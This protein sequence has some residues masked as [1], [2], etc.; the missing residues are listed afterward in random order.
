MILSPTAG[1]VFFKPV[2]TAGSSIEFALAQSCGPNDLLVGGM[3]GEE[4][5]SGFKPQNNV[6][7]EDGKIYRKFHTHTFPTFLE[8]RM[9]SEQFSE[10]E[11]LKWITMV[12]NPWAAVVSYYW[13]NMRRDDNEK[14]T[15]N[16]NTAQKQTSDLFH[17]VM[18]S[19]PVDLESTDN[20]NEKDFCT[21]HDF[22]AKHNIQMA[23]DHRIDHIIRFE[24]LQE[25]FD[26][27]TSELYLHNVPIP[28]FKTTQ[29]KVK[30]HY[31]FYYNDVTK[32]IVGDAFK[33]YI[34][35]FDYKFE[36]KGRKLSR[37]DRA[38]R[39]KDKKG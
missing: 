17:Q 15:I 4:S 35:K 37:R 3:E 9:T 18:F 20:P 38:K 39:R 2:K 25:D 16:E 19:M 10:I 29:Q 5:G 12:R 30:R 27:V 28:R 6:Y 26:K 31:S 14:W 1:F 33:D 13:W 8:N 22:V 36:Y 7:I 23:M 24:H 34:E 32:R 21:F 11:Q